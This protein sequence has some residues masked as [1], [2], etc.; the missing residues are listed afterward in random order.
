M[1]N[2]LLLLNLGRLTS[3]ELVVEA[4]V[5]GLQQVRKPPAF[6]PDAGYI[7]KAEATKMV[8]ACRAML[9]AEKAEAE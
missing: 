4:G 7:T 8:A 5:A 2:R 6:D 1:P 3:C 9:P